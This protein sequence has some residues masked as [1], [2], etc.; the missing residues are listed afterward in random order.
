MQSTLPN[1]NC[2][3]VVKIC[4]L[5]K[6]RI[7]VI[8][9]IGDIFAMRFSRDLKILLE[10]AKVEFHEFQKGR[11]D[12]KSSCCRDKSSQKM[13]SNQSTNI[14]SNFLSQK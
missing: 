14:M 11:V 3:G 8:R 7:T 2:L 9:T 12:Y 13:F 10:S 6:A 5:Q 1:S 4:G